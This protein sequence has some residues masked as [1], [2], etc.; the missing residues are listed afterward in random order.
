MNE[1]TVDFIVVGAGSAGAALASRLTESGRYHVLLLEAGGETHPLSRV[2]I[3]FAKFINRP[4]VNWLYASEPEANTGGRPIPVPRGRMLGGSSAI[5]GMVWVRGQRQDYDHWAQLGNRG[6]SYQDV[7]PIFKAMESYGGGDGEIRGRDGPIKVSDIDESGRLYDSFFAAAATVGLR[8]NRDYNGADQEGIA[9]TQ[10]S[11]GRGRRMSTSHCYLEPARLRAN[12]TIETNAM[13]ESLILGA[14]AASACAIRR[15][16]ETRGARGPRGDRVGGRHRLAAAP[17]AVRHRPGGAPQ[18]VRHQGPPRSARR[19]REPA[20]PLG[21]AHEM[22]R[23]PSRRDLQ[24][25]CPRRPRPV[26][27][28]PL[29]R[30]AQGLPELP[31]VA[32]AR[33]LQDPRGPRQPRRHA[34]GAALPDDAQPEARQAGRNDHHHPSAASREQGQRSRDRR[35][36]KQAAGDPVQLPGRAR[37]SRLRARL[38][39]HRAP[40]RRGAAARLA[41]RRGVRPRLK[42]QVRRP[43]SSTSLPARP[44]PPTIPSAPA[45]WAATRPPSSTTACA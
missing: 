28:P 3:S 2:P 8:P 4:G 39:A 20:R 13:A 21:A 19:R 25:A 14:A 45:G 7:L 27:G 34:H 41:W 36:C 30:R 26:A 35:R 31:G 6:W 37:R 22:A 16:R 44:R 40:H 12:L 9:M 43:S 17:G 15:R 33:F 10:G 23:R 24:R 1:F 11:I 29:H 42:G 38:H 18:E 5:N 32:D